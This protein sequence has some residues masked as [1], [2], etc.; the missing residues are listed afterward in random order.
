[1]NTLNRRCGASPAALQ[2]HVRYLSF[3]G[4][5]RPSGR[6]GRGRQLGVGEVNEIIPGHA[7]TNTRFFLSF[8]V[9]MHSFVY[10]FTKGTEG[11]FL[12][13]VFSI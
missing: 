2:R 8:L 1:M 10:I 11:F 6:D 4:F 5:T 3:D 13:N 12:R 9:K 7:H